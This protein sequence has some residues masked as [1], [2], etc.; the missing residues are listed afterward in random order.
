MFVAAMHGE[1]VFLKSRWRPSHEISVILDRVV[2]HDH[3]RVAEAF[4]VGLL[5]GGSNVMGTGCC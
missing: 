1:A 2:G 3:G 5:L 4:Q